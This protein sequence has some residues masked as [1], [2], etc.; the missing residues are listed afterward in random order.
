MPFQTVRAGAGRR[1]QGGGGC[2]SAAAAPL[3]LNVVATGDVRCFVEPFVFRCADNQS[4]LDM[5]KVFSP[6]P[7]S[8]FG[9][10]HGWWSR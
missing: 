10:N 8:F 1:E 4:V 5:R 2:A 3:I 9:G 7:P 6:S